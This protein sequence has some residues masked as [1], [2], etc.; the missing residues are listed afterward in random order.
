MSCREIDTVCPERYR[1]TFIGTIF[2]NTSSCGASPQCLSEEAVGS[3][4]R[5]GR[6]AWCLAHSGG[7]GRRLLSNVP[8]ALPCRAPPAPTWDVPRLVRTPP[9]L[10]PPCPRTIFNAHLG[11]NL[12]VDFG[13]VR[14][15]SWSGAEVPEPNPKA[16]RLAAWSVSAGPAAS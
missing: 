2:K 8:T 15:I 7:R 5:A 1:D 16:G 14:I 3:R 10:Q 4:H 6:P 13:C 11:Q 12:D 9:T